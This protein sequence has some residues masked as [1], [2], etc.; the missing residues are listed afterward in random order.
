MAVMFSS[1]SLLQ[2]MGSAYF[3]TLSAQDD[4]DHIGLST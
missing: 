1:M 3:G 4:S 2:L